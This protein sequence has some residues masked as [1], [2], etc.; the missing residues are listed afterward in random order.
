MPNA[1]ILRELASPKN[2]GL[3]IINLK[4]NYLG[5]CDVKDVK[6]KV[7]ELVGPLTGYRH[8]ELG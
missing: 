2:S 3:N 4:S 7:N 6:D 8:V 5:N 1:D